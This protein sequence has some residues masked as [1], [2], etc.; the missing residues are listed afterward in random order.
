M[1]DPP[2]WQTGY[3]ISTVREIKSLLTDPFT[4]ESIIVPDIPVVMAYK[5]SN[6]TCA[7][8]GSAYIN[9]ILTLGAMKLSHILDHKYDFISSDGKVYLHS[10]P[11]LKELESIPRA[12][13]YIVHNI[14]KSKSIEDMRKE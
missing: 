10:K 2:C 12:M 3:R 5:K 13:D 8:N 7:P 9:G 1:V 6:R 14:N 4:T 11:S